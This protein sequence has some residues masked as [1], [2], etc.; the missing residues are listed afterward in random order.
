[1][2]L[3]RNPVSSQSED[4]GKLCKM[5]LVIVFFLAIKKIFS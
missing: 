3:R 4:N 5:L 1:M 2:V